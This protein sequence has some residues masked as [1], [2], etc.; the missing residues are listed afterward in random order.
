MHTLLSAMRG[1]EV[2]RAERLF[3]PQLLW[4]LDLK[5]PGVGHVML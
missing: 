1:F 4:T 2:A 3:Q 5:S